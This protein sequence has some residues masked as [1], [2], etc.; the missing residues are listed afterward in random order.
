LG[1][2]KKI[3]IIW[4]DEW[5]IRSHINISLMYFSCLNCIIFISH[6]HHPK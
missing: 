3:K 4:C 2:E 6:F 1:R 5:I